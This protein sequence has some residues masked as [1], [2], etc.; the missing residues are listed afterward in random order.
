MPRKTA[1][2]RLYERSN[3]IFSIRDGARFISTGTRNR[4]EAEAAL[5]RFIVQKDRPAGPSTPDQVTVADVLEIYGEKHAPTV[6]APERIGYAIQALLPILG[7]LPVAIINGGVC[8]RYAETRNKAAGTVRRE[9]GALQAAINFAYS[10]GYLTAARKVRLPEKS[11]PR[12][13]WLTRDEV[14]RLLWAAYRSPKGKHLAR[15]ILTAIYSGTRSDA[16][17][18]LRF[19]P[20][21]VG[22]WCDTE[23]GMMYRRAAGQAETKKRT[24]PIPIPRPLLAH[25]RRWERNGARYAVEVGGQR[26]A[27]VKTAWKRALAEAGI[28]HCTR[29]DLRHTAITWAMQR[30]MDRWLAAGFF[31]VTMDVL[32]QTYAHHHPDYLQGAAE[33]MARKS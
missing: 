25:L 21:T 6:K 14:A 12:D 23:S 4:R 5:A 31:G 1:G 18:G 29:H 22:G 17:L 27:S 19:M 33:I 32:E 2:A 13:R 30:G 26:V 9:L 7:D 10:E 16:I 28:D 15:F 8:R 24:P 11:A 3:G 20:S